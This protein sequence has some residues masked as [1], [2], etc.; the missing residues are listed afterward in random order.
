MATRKIK[1]AKDLTTNELI[2]FRNHAK[3][4]YMSD[5][6]TVEDK[7]NS[8]SSGG[9][10]VDL[11]GYVQK[12]ELSSVATSGNYNDLSNKPTIPSAVTESTV[13]GWGFTKNAGTVTGVKANGTAITLSSGVANIPAASTSAYGV[14][15]LSSATNSTSTSLAATASAVKAAYDLANSYKGTVTSVKINGTTKSPSSGV[16]DLGTVI[17]AHQTLKTINGESIV[18]SGD[19]TI[20]GSGGSGGE[21][22]IRY[23]TEF[24]VEDFIEACASS[25]II[26][27]DTTEL[28][29]AMK[30]NKVICVPYRGYDKGF[31]VASYKSGE[32]VEYPDMY[33]QKGDVEYYAWTGDSHE[34]VGDATTFNSVQVVEMAGGEVQFEVL[35][36][37]IYKITDPL[38]Y[39]YPAFYNIQKGTTIHFMS[40]TSG[41]TLEFIQNVFW[42][43]GEMPQIEP[44]TYYELS[45]IQNSFYDYNVVLTPFKN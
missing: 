23:F 24:T 36:N 43:N 10:D 3:A 19:I 45:I 32:N 11:S 34:L 2:Y 27:S 9:G 7:I 17:T 39:L 31:V 22:D 25:D 13:S 30:S 29:N 15:K 33:L 37:H 21:E 38:D 26:T 35:D 6:T 5:G 16:V 28:F 4:T 44:N 8:I 18:G 1:D 12:T 20:E 40:G 42:A 41:T 14:T